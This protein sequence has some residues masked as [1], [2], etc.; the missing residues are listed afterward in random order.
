L[1]QTVTSAGLGNIYSN[2][3]ISFSSCSGDLTAS[4]DGGSSYV[5]CISIPS[6]P[7]WGTID[8][9][10]AGEVYFAGVFANGTGVAKSTSLRDGFATPT[11][12]LNNNVDLGGQVSA[13]VGPNPQGL[14]GQV[15][16]TVDRSG[17][18]N[19]GNVYLLASVDPPGGDPADVML[20]RSEDGGQTW[21]APIRVNDDT[22]GNNAWQWLAMMDV[23]PNGRIDVFW[24]DT[25]ANPGTFLS[26]FYYSFSNDGG[27]T[28]S[29]NLAVSPSFDPHQGW[30]QQSKMGDYNDLVS[31]PNG[32]DV[33][34]TATLGGEQNIY[35]LRINP[36]QCPADL[37]G[38]FTV[39]NTDLQ[40][41]YPNWATTS[42]IG[43]LDENGVVDI[44]DLITILNSAGGC[45]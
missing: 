18:P 35:H 29:T 39:D 43:D 11:F 28:W 26:E 4:Y 42:S 6:N 14:M 2:W 31:G 20:S 37:N 3:N 12:D 41:A 23:A 36:G 5:N 7:R 21:S 9:G 17:G 22:P 33:I 45:L 32:V 34:Y 10:L 1:D 15:Y 27:R 30:P 19:A 16:V 24:N 25:R 40:L 8:V 13:S 38:D 44:R